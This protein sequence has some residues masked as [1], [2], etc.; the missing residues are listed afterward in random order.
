M[1]DAKETKPGFTKGPYEICRIDGVPIGVGPV[2]TR[3]GIN[4]FELECNS[5]IPDDAEKREFEVKA[6]L[7]AQMALF[8]AA[9]DMYDALELLLDWYTGKRD[10][11][12]SE[13][14]SARAAL[15][16]ARGEA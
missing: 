13:V 4:V 5:I 15:A 7:E 12:G 16:K 6:H 8:A 3:N 1:N 10:W 2:T 9:P 11:D 14:A